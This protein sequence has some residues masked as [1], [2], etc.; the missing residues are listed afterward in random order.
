MNEKL[1]A[2]LF[3]KEGGIVMF[4]ILFLLVI[5]YQ[6][7]F[8]EPQTRCFVYLERTT[9]KTDTCKYS[10]IKDGNKIL[11]EISYCDETYEL[12][13]DSAYSAHSCEIKQKATARH[14]KFERKTEKM[15][16]SSDAQSQEYKM[17]NLPWYQTPFSLSEFITSDK[18][19]VMFY[20]ATLY[21]EQEKKDNAGGAIMKMVARK[22]KNEQITLPQGA[23]PSVKVTIT[24]P[25]L[26][27]LFWKITYWYRESDGIVVRYEDVRG[28]P[29]TPKTI[30]TLINETLQ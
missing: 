6:I 26:K 2:Y 11:L 12:K 10:I 19:D 27:S 29:G 22:M 18:K 9:D 5:G 20:T 15:I 7:V 16:C 14:I 17:E 13:T 21:D 24:L 1:F 30:G 3:F 25:G 28:G 23:Y 8:A 4:I